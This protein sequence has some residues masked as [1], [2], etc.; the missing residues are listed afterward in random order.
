MN[1]ICIGLCTAQRP[2]LLRKCLDSLA[3]LNL[4]EGYSVRLL[5]VDNEAEP[6][7]WPIVY[8]FA[9]SCPFP[10]NYFHEPSCGIP[11]ARNRVLDEAMNFSA[12][13]IAF[14]DDDEVAD[15]DWLAA[16]MA[17]EY[18][19]TPVIR[20]LHIT[21]FP[22]KMPFWALPAKFQSPEK[23]EG[24][25]KDRAGTGNVRFSSM[26]LKHGLRSNENLCFLGGEDRE[27][28]T[29][30]RLAGFTIKQTAKAIT[31]EHAH[32]SRYTL[33]GQAYRSYWNGVA[34]A[35][36]KAKLSSSRSEIM[37]YYIKAGPKLLFGL[38]L[39]TFAP[40]A[41]ILGGARFKRFIVKGAKEASEAVGI[42]AALFGILPQ[43]YADIIG[44]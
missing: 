34:R 28:F 43:P 37:K 21:L 12:D 9:A 19:D 3:A 25:I 32:P 2:V 10:V 18:L 29:F 17:P 35:K 23:I 33:R 26:L 39:L 38:A 16:L 44:H 22:E 11:M 4:P 40:F 42:L 41:L 14:L 36:L 15:P 30:A 20:G 24:K 27:F 13:W 31:W 6:N 8:D 7:N 5:V 1:S